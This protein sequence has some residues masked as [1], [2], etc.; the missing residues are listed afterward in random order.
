MKSKRKIVFFRYVLLIWALVIAAA[1]LTACSGN[2]VSLD[3]NELELGVGQ[4][5]QLT[6]QAPD[7]AELEWTS[8][9]ESVAT[10]QDGLVTATGEGNCTVRVSA[11]VDGAEYS[12]SCAVTVRA[13]E[14]ISYTVE[15]YVQNDDY[16]YERTGSETFSAPAGST[17]TAEYDAAQDGYFVDTQRSV[18]SATLTEGTVLQVYYSLNHNIVTVTWANGTIED[19]RIYESGDVLGED[20]VPVEDF[21]QR[22]ALTQDGENRYYFWDIGGIKVKRALTEEDFLGAADGLSITEN[23]TR[24]QLFNTATFNNAVTLNGDGTYTVSPTSEWGSDTSAYLFFTASSDTLYASVKIE[25]ASDQADN[26]AGFVLVDSENMDRN[27]QFYLG[28]DGT[29]RILWQNNS[30]SWASG[31]NREVWSDSQ[32]TVDA[33]ENV[34]EIAV[35]D[36]VVRF[37]L[38]GIYFCTEDIASLTGPG[39]EAGVFS[40]TRSFNLGITQWRFNKPVTQFSEVEFVYGSEAEQAI[41]TRML[42]LDKSQTTI[43]ASDPDS[44]VLTAHSSEGMGQVSWSTSDPSVVT[45]SG[46]ELTPVGSGVA[47]VTAS[48]QLD[49][50]TYTASCTVTV[51]YWT[52]DFV[53]EGGTLYSVT[54]LNGDGVAAE[55]IPE[56]DLTGDYIHAEWDTPASEL[57][58]V[59]SDVTVRAIY[60]LYQYDVVYYRQNA[61]TGTY[62]R[63]DEQSYYAETS[64]VSIAP[65]AP[66]NYT[67]NGEES[68]LEGTASSEER[69]QLEVY[70]DLVTASVDVVVDL[71]GGEQVYTAYYGLGL[72]DGDT[73]VADYAALFSRDGYV[74]EI[75]G[76]L[77]NVTLDEEYFSALT[78]NMTIVRH[79][80]SMTFSSASGDVVNTTVNADGSV[81]MQASGWNGAWAY[82]TGSGTSFYAQTTLRSR[83]QMDGGTV[84]EDISA[85][86]TVRGSD[87]SCFS[88]YISFAYNSIR[89][90]YGH[91]WAGGEADFGDTSSGAVGSWII[92]TRLPAENFVS[93]EGAVVGLSYSNGTF[94][95]Y[96]DGEEVFAIEESELQFAQGNVTMGSGWT[97]GLASW[98][99]H[100]SNFS[101]F[102][103]LFEEDAIP[104]QE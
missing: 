6:A 77:T 2:S 54:V 83:E 94:R 36:G 21:A 100:R 69:L 41:Q 28:S 24:D 90:N 103:V 102:Y 37:W 101:D 47:V 62:E 19:Y 16:T 25:T 89:L 35:S 13:A 93:G 66:E 80:G 9:N 26:S 75:N 68:V 33:R 22:F 44:S 50:Q 34:L 73:A 85:G 98:D 53:G 60:Y 15:T 65:S 82:F 91:V 3:R 74:Y 40:G 48:A 58:S 99:T 87:G 11:A 5:A 67:L 78:Q 63:Y 104:E 43:D 8:D 97:V 52:V 56:I 70:Y 49:G 51:N 57:V 23:Y 96:I 81:D 84:D 42:T 45:V 30:F 12:A 1:V 18:L 71:G 92:S 20:G 88:F 59:R 55:D 32:A 14:P 76:K 10:V 72:Y 4:S 31:T 39:D 7:G 95:I 29:Q 64:A 79:A 27:V 17:V 38:N 46:G 61:R 86:F